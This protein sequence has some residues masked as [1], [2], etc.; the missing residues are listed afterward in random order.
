MQ[1]GLCTAQPLTHL[2]SACFATQLVASRLPHR[3]G[4][5]LYRKFKDMQARPSHI[6]TRTGNNLATSMSHLYQI[7]KA[8]ETRPSLPHL[9]RTGLQRAK[10]DSSDSNAVGAL[11]EVAMEEVCS[12]RVHGDV[13]YRERVGSLSDQHVSPVCVFNDCCLSATRAAAINSLAGRA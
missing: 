6:C 11:D 1:A 8:V 2:V 13:A 3:A 12:A 5:S 9:P 7:C 10:S 4:F